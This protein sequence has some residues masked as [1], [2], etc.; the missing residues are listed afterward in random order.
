MTIHEI[1][2][3]IALFLM[4]LMIC[5]AGFVAHFPKKD[6]FVRPALMKDFGQFPAP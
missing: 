1:A 5:E 4:Q 2:R 3:M 6:H